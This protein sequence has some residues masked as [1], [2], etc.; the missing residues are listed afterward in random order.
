MHRLL[1]R[2]LAGKAELVELDVMQ[3]H[4]DAGQVVRRQVDFLAEE[5]AAHVARPKD[6]RKLEQQATRSAARV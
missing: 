2:V 1:E 5:A 3:E 6:L 4:V